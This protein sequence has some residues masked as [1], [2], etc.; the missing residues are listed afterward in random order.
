MSPI[1][2]NTALAA[3]F[4]KEG[5]LVAIPTE[6]VYGLA[7]MAN[8]PAAVLSVFEAKKRP[9]FDPL[10]LHF[11]SIDAIH[12]YA[13][14]EDGPLLKLAQQFWPGPLSLL[15]PKTDL[16]PDLVTSGL[17]KVAVRIPKQALTLALLKEL[18]A[19]LAA[20]S[21]NPF[22]YISPT[23][24]EHVKKQLGD[25][26]AY[27][28]DGGACEV[29]LESTIVGLE[30]NTVCVYRLGG[31]S[32]ED[33]ELVCGKVELKLNV[34]SNP[35]A[36]GQLKSH[37]APKKPLYFGELKSLLVQYA[38]KKRSILSFGE[39]EIDNKMDKVFDLSPEK[40]IKEAA[41]NLF[42]MLRAADDDNK[43]EVILAQQL[44]NEGLG[45]AINDRLKR[46]SV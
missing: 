38:G 29:G 16:V 4:L 18:N 25:K 3:Q 34:S 23:T 17:E 22:G 39:I 1:G 35:K 8:N 30:E 45:R 19:P 41:M 13:A 46:A 7:A 6:T 44:P 21:A 42:A 15:L 11:H 5:K 2:K 37:Y 12:P 33:I 10:I 24:A 20:P 9:S 31:L 27:I 28:L 32:L 26:V 14:L 36:P 43:S 40:N